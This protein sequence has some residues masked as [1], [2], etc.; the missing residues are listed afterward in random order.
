M[1]SLRKYYGKVTIDWSGSLYCVIYL[2]WNYQE[3]WVN[4][5]MT[6]YIDTLIRKFQ[7]QPSKKT[8]YSP[9]PWIKPTYGASKQYPTPTD[10]SPTLDKDNI[11]R[12][13]NFLG[14]LLYYARMVDPTL[15]VALSY[16]ETQK[17][18][19]TQITIKNM[20][21]LLDYC[22]TFPNETIRYTK[23]DMILKVQSDSG[24]LNVVGYKSRVGGYFIWVMNHVT[25]MIIM[26]GFS[27]IPKF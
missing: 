23:S 24:Y 2:E 21:Q 10:I 5:S 18:K 25:I 20:N 16:L 6:N 4:L 9:F 22:C 13:Q 11:T 12:I 19:E 7:Y 27:L 3:K 1:K 15:L 17:T 26:E 14:T 8:Q